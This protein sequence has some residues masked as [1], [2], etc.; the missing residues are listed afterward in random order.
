MTMGIEARTLSRSGLGVELSLQKLRGMVYRSKPP[1]NPKT[2]LRWT[3]Q[4]REIRA[5]IRNME[6]V[7]IDERNP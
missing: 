4:Q 6:A 7:L 5:R 2:L 3:S 1:G